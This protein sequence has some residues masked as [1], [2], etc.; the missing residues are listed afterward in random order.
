MNEEDVLW[1]SFAN[2]S[3]AGEEIDSL[4]VAL[5]EVL[6]D[7]GL[8]SHRIDIDSEEG[9]DLKADQDWVQGYALYSF[10]IVPARGRTTNRGWLSL[11]ISFWRPEDE[12]G[13][14]WPGGSLAKLYVGFSPPRARGWSKEDLVL[15]GAGQSLDAIPRSEYR[16]SGTGPSGMAE[17]WFFCVSLLELRSRADLDRE[18]AR[19]VRLLLEGRPDE[20]AFAGSSAVIRVQSKA[21]A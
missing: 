4:V 21:V 15:D 10:K 7:G 20:V 2:A 8:G 19:P 6:A 17:A 9:Y 5:R 14:G 1:R 16:W 18:I 11:A 3:R 12:R 13:N